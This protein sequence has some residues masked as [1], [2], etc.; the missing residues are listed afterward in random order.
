MPAAAGTAI[1]AVLGALLISVLETALPFLKISPFVQL[2]IIGAVILI[3]VA[4]NARAETRAGRQ[5]LERSSP[6]GRAKP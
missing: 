1:G 6:E 2:A 4:V 5:I 3:A